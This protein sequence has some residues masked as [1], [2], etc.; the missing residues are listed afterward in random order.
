[1]RKYETMLILRP[2]LEEDQLKAL[3]DEIMAFIQARRVTLP[4]STSGA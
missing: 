4:G 1:M 3:L 2:D